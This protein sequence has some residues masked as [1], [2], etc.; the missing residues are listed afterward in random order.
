MKPPDDVPIYNT[1]AIVV[2]R[3][4]YGDHDLIL[5]CLTRDKGLITVLAKNAKKSVKRFSGILELFYVLDVVVRDSRNMACL[6]EASLYEPFEGFR[7]DIIP[8]AY[9]SYW[10]ESMI[11]F[12]EENVPQERLY[13]LLFHA[14]LE[15][16]SGKRSPEE[17]SVYFQLKFLEFS[18]L[19]PEISR[20]M[21]C[22]KPLDEIQH[23][24][25]MVDLKQGGLICNDCGNFLPS[26]VY[27]SKGALKQ[28]LWFRTAEPGKGSVIRFSK[29]S[30]MECLDFLER[31]VA[32]QMDR[33]TGSLKFLRKTRERE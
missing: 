25:V 29:A 18:G 21:V 9:A 31:F 26:R 7:S 15:L 2:R 27:L 19:E 20:C 3:T 10:A 32:Y 17:L 6:Q 30:L 14:F 8:F 23:V 13:D 4:E 5:T 11:R 1:Q 28:M 16:D 24:R 12:L 22:Q 33:E